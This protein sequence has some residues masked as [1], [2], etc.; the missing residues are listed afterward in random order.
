MPRP[1]SSPKRRP[2]PP[3]T[4]SGWFA[5]GTL[6]Q[7]DQ[8]AG[9]LSG[10]YPNAET[11]PAEHLPRARQYLYSIYWS[12]S[13]LLTVGYGDVTPTSDEEIV[14]ACF[15]MLFGAT[16]FAAMTGTMASMLQSYSYPSMLRRQRLQQLNAFLG[17]A[18]V[19]A[20]LSRRIK[21]YMQRHLDH[22][23]LNEDAILDGLPPRLRAELRLSGLVGHASRIPLFRALGGKSSLEKLCAFL[24][25]RTFVPDEIV[26]RLREPMLDA[27]FLSYGSVRV[28]LDD[29]WPAHGANVVNVL[30][31]PD[32]FGEPFS[33]RERA[34]TFAMQ[35]VRWVDCLTLSTAAY[36]R[37]FL[38]HPDWTRAIKVATELRGAELEAQAAAA[39]K[40][41]RQEEGSGSEGEG[42][43]GGG[44]PAG[45]VRRRK[46]NPRSV[47]TAALMRVIRTKLLVERERSERGQRAARDSSCSSPASP[48]RRVL[49]YAA[50]GANAARRGLSPAGD[51]RPRQG[52]RQEGA[53]RHGALGR[54][55]PAEAQGAGKAEGGGAAKGAKPASATNLRSSE[56]EEGE[57]DEDDESDVFSSSSAAAATA[58]ASEAHRHVSSRRFIER[59]RKRLRA[60]RPEFQ[61][62]FKDLPVPEQLRLLHEQ[63]GSL[64]TAFA[65]S[66]SALRRDLGVQ[67]GPIAID[68][69]SRSGGSGGRR[70]AEPTGSN[71]SSRRSSSPLTPSPETPAPPAAAAATMRMHRRSNLASPSGAGST[72]PRAQ[73]MPQRAGSESRLAAGCG[74]SIP[75]DNL[76]QRPLSRSPHPGEAAAAGSDGDGCGSSVVQ[77]SATEPRGLGSSVG[78]ADSLASGS[79]LGSAIAEHARAQGAS[80]EE[81]GDGDGGDVQL[82]RTARAGSLQRPQPLTEL[83]MPPQDSASA[84]TSGSNEQ[85]SATGSKAG[86]DVATAAARRPSSETAGGLS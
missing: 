18:K 41:R 15:A 9:W 68:L 70:S 16:A 62:E 86:A 22:N 56:E 2:R 84:P 35:A 81:E 51:G 85:G 19:P 1:A 23:T 33:H 59:M 7:P 13:T 14:F 63:V 57:S 32:V 74:R 46:S 64:R 8:P 26:V 47:A 49:A 83:A 69:F 73:S 52:W 61:V 80:G 50:D 30:T 11:E 53:R 38:E 72:H 40:R 54:V 17:K 45:R 24:E 66:M 10:W 77:R 31:P 79:A 60:A 5:T 43:E 29:A 6:L 27:F 82:G 12:L 20:E 21:T 55:A 67:H 65:D 75:L 28:L 78:V 58:S 76:L 39:H 34:Y 42:E 37:L 36:L 25:V 44:G 71:G 4:L 48:M 3:L